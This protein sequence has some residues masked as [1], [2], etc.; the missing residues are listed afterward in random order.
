MRA[1]TFPF[2][3]LIG[4]CSFTQFPA[5]LHPTSELGCKIKLF[6]DKTITELC[7][8]VHSASSTQST[9]G[10]T[11]VFKLPVKANRKK[12]DYLLWR[13][14]VQPM[15]CTTGVRQV[16]TDSETL[17]TCGH[18]WYNFTPHA[19]SCSWSVSLLCERVRERRGWSSDN[20]C[21]ALSVWCF[22]CHL[23]FLFFSPVIGYFKKTSDLRR[24][25]PGDNLCFSFPAHQSW[26]FTSRHHLSIHSAALSLQSLLGW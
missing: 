13:S 16:R 10:C 8:G 2:K 7:N 25:W 18:D 14:L 3:I 5:W 23:V 17:K 20:I 26:V 22:L 19:C 4:S 15:W 6:S 24:D 9:Q 21:A 11:F 1:E 12:R